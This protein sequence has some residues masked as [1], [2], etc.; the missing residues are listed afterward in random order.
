M[1]FIEEKTPITMRIIMWRRDPLLCKQ[2]PLLG[3]A[4]NIHARNNRKFSFLCGPRRDV[5]SRTKRVAGI[6][7]GGG[8]EYLHCS[9]ATRKRRGKEIDHTV[10]EIYIYIYIYK[11]GDLALQVVAVSN[12]RE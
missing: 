10:P 9:P 4:R 6:Q 11:Y 7:H 5:I 3:N 12:L 8:A 2:Q 1:S